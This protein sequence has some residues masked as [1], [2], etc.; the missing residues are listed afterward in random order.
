MGQKFGSRMDGWSA[1]LL[2]CRKV[3]VGNF[4]TVSF[5]CGSL[6]LG[7]PSLLRARKTFGRLNEGASVLRHWRKESFCFLWSAARTK[8]GRGLI[9]APHHP[10][11]WSSCKSKQN[12]SV[13]VMMSFWGVAWGKVFKHAERMRGSIKFHSRFSPKAN[14]LEVF[15]LCREVCVWRNI[16]VLLLA[17]YSSTTIMLFVLLFRYD[18]TTYRNI[19]IK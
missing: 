10:S 16:M 14:M 13:D 8:L 6:I 2:G 3:I 5:C 9:E 1:G 19:W 7:R 12:I 11:R 17:F 4:Y 18:A 15:G